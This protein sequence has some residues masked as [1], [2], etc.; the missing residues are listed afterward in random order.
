MAE[1]SFRVKRTVPRYPFIA[2]VEVAG[3]NDGTR[4]AARISDLSV[5]GC[6][7]DTLNPVALHTELR[8]RIR[9]GDRACELP[10]KVIYVHAGYGMGV[11]FG[12]APSD[13][14]GVLEN[15]L[16]DLAATKR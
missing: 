12:S 9:H 15:W 11:L 8:L 7:I 14:L 10:G 16:T 5:R 2:E 13:Q 1:D 6:Y 3:M 4:L